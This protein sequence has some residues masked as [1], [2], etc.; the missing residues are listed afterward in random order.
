MSFWR[1]KFIIKRFRSPSSSSLRQPLHFCV[2]LFAACWK[3]LLWNK[4]WPPVTFLQALQVYVSG[5]FVVYPFCVQLSQ[6]KAR[7]CWFLC[8]FD[9]L[10]SLMNFLHTSTMHTLPFRRPDLHSRHCC[11]PRLQSRSKSVLEVFAMT[12]IAAST[13]SVWCSTTT[14]CV[15]KYFQDW[16]SN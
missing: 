3:C 15:R 2:P 6:T 16:I 7:P 9:R 13:A 1:W 4:P 5:F 12:G 14:T 8:V 10:S 11:V